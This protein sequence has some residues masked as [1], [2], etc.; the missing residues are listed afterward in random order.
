MLKTVP[1]QIIQFSLSTQF[2]SIWSIDRTL[3]GATILGLRGPGRY[4]NEGMFRIPQSSS[5]NEPNH[6]IA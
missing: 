2:S 3:S 6:Q 4:G 5:I 1:F